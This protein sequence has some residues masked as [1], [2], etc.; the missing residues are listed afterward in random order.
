M[1]WSRDLKGGSLPGESREGRGPQTRQS[2]LGLGASCGLEVGPKAGGSEAEAGPV[3]SGWHHR[4]L[5]C[6]GCG[7]L[8]SRT[9]QTQEDV[10]VGG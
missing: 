8:L 9:G 5:L 7:L 1:L 6:P 3:A 2:C 4:G 10:P